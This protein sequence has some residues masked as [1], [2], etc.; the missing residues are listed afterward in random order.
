MTTS[1][2]LRK[3]ERV[4]I[5]QGYIEGH[6]VHSVTIYQ[7]NMA[8]LG[9]GH[10]TVAAPWMCP[11]VNNILIAVFPKIRFTRIPGL[12]SISSRP[13]PPPLPPLR[14]LYSHFV[15]MALCMQAVR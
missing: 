7:L 13:H 2:E 1:I 15:S 3:Q 11:I 10:F 6:Q 14:R 8:D 5:T 9:S 12:D 4:E